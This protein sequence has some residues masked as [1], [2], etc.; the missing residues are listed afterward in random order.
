MQAS[1]SRSISIAR[2]LGD[3]EKEEAVSEK[4]DDEGKTE[5]DAHLEKFICE[6]LEKVKIGETSVDFE[7]EIEA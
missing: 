1:S 7:D 2:V 4:K 3:V 5:A 6:Q